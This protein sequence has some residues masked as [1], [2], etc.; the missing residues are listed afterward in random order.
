MVAASAKRAR[1][2]VIPCREGKAYPAV[3]LAGLPACWP[4]HRW[5]A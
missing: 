2:P 5:C 1:K 3:V 4:E